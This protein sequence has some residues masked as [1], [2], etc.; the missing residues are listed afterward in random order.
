MFVLLFLR[1]E[2][3]LLWIP[4]LSNYKRNSYIN[5][6]FNF[7]HNIIII[8]IFINYFGVLLTL[9]HCK[10]TFPIQLENPHVIDG[11]QIWVG[12]S[13]C[14]PSGHAVNTSHQN[15]N[16]PDFIQELGNS[17]G[18][19]DYH[20]IIIY[21]KYFI[22]NNNNKL[23]NFSRIVPSG[24][25]VFFSSYTVME[26]HIAQWKNAVSGSSSIWE[27]IGQYKNIVQ[28]PRDGWML[29]RVMDDYYG[30]IKENVRRGAVFFAVCRGKVRL[31]F[32]IYV[33]II[34][35]FILFCIINI[36]VI[37]LILFLR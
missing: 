26:H 17:I 7:K 28:E 18:I 3:Y 8:I 20:L 27:R 23:V 32:I 19:I 1:A 10:R 35:L 16:K 14:G 21:L 9:I 36:Y 37:K 22:N 2:L 34:D 11:S 29:N 4:L 12:V 31:H 15:R 33:K 6:T 24:L 5:I 25:L 13:C 30:K